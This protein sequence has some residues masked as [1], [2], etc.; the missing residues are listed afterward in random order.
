[1][2]LKASENLD[3][4]LGFSYSLVWTDDSFKLGSWSIKENFNFN[5]AYQNFGFR[6]SLPNTNIFLDAKL[7]NYK[8]NKFYALR[9]GAKLSNF[10]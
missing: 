2:C 10:F 8:G 7:Y 9:L 4:I 1:M 6:Y 5:E 3:L